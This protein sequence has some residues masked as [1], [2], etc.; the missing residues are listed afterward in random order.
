MALQMHVAPQINVT[1]WPSVS[2]WLYAILTFVSSMAAVV[3]F[4][5]VYK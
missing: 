1:K 2:F 3:V 4:K 5:S